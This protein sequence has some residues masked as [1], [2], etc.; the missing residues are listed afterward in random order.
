M[1][2]IITSTNTSKINSLKNAT[3]ELGMENVEII[4]ISVESDVSS[5][6]INS[7]I[8]QGCL[9]RNNN[10]KKI[11]NKEKIKY[12]YI[13]SIEG[14]FEE[15]NKE[16]P[17]I[18]TYVVIEDKNFKIST[19]KSLGLR[20]TKPM[21]S[22]LKSGKSLNKLIEQI[23]NKTNNKQNGGITGYL[24]QGILN[25]SSI[26]KD[27]VI[28]ALVPMLYEKQRHALNESVKKILNR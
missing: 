27:A 19:G 4:P 1:K 17:F 8:L 11:L 20:I 7:E 14:G 26:D 13:C 15:D 21:M 24:S 18:I 28:S 2:I 6:P 23:D 12:D 10:A 9:N 3:I 22:Y 5:K 16:Y 25:R